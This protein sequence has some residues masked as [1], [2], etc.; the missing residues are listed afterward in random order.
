M[1]PL[2]GQYIQRSVG[3]QRLLTD[4]KNLGEYFFPSKD[5]FFFFFFLGGIPSNNSKSWDFA[6]INLVFLPAKN[7]C[8]Y[9]ERQ[10]PRRVSEQSHG[11]RQGFA[12]W[13]L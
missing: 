13:G 8:V 7:L 4:F 5:K 9:E 11:N 3:G 2:G 10:C 6:F 1:V 12:F